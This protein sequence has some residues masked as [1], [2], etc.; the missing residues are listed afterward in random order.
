MSSG[1]Q[2]FQQPRLVAGISPCR[3]RRSRSK[4]CVG[5]W[6][7]TAALQIAIDAVEISGPGGS[8]WAAD[9]R[10]SSDNSASAALSGPAAPPRRST[11]SL[12]AES[13]VSEWSENWLAYTPFDAMT[14][15]AA[16]LNS[17]PPAVLSA[18][19]DYLSSRRQS[20][21]R[22]GPICRRRGI[23]GRKKRCTTASNSTSAS[24]AVSPFNR[25]IR[26]RSIQQIRPDG[27][28]KPC[29]KTARY[30][31]T[32]ARKTAARPMHTLP[33]VEN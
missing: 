7:M 8:Q 17:M 5:F 32:S 28:G 27:C 13:P 9:A 33:V 16:D 20:F 29:A 25:K 22:P 11:E 6:Q 19:G 14:L 31:Q 21:C 18:I 15:N 30:W 2:R 1:R 23:R 26:P 12:R 24:A 10:A 4:P 3:P